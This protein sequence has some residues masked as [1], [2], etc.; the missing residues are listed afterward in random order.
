MYR[1]K[2]LKNNAKTSLKKNYALTVITCIIGLFLLSLYGSTT[3]A[4]L[5]GVE[6]VQNYFDNGHFMTNSEID[7]LDSGLYK[8]DIDFTKLFNLSPEELTKLGYNES[9]I[10]Y[11]KSLDSTV[12]DKDS[13]VDRLKVKDGFLKPFLNFASSDLKIILENVEDLSISVINGT[14]ASKVGNIAILRFDCNGFN[15]DVY[16]KCIKSRLC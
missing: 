8:Q 1:F 5:N 6:R 11:I 16:H 4:L 9:A 7:Y 13:L 10:K 14:F 3:S 2:D 12:Q 15:Q